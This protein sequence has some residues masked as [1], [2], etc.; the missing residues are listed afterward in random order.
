MHK[1]GS[2]RSH[3]FGAPA[4]PPSTARAIGAPPNRAVP[5]VGIIGAPPNRAVPGVGII[6]AGAVGAPPNRP[7]HERTRIVRQASRN[8]V[9]IAR[10]RDPVGRPP[11]ARHDAMPLALPCHWQ[12]GCSSPEIL[13]QWGLESHHGG[14]V[15]PW[16]VSETWSTTINFRS[17]LFSLKKLTRQFRYKENNIAEI[18][19]QYIVKD[20]GDC[21]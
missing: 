9:P 14:Q 19:I 12:E 13:K 8:C 18:L 6:G 16:V 5:G 15:Q 3:G 7:V 21:G 20:Q 17:S 2:R 11:G 4:A 10:C 1:G